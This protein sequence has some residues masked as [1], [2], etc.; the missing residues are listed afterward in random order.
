[1]ERKKLSQNEIVEEIFQFGGHECGRDRM[2]NKKIQKE[3]LESLMT[4]GIPF[5]KINKIRKFYT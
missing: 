3:D 5:S 2:E 1:M 4:S